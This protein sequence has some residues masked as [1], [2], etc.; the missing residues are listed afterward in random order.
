MKK[1]REY[2]LDTCTLIEF[3]GGNPSVVKHVMEAGPELCCMSVI[4]LHELYYGAYYAGEKKEEYYEREMKMIDK[5]LEKFSVLSLPEKAIGYAQIKNQLRKKGQLIDE[6]DM[7]IAGQA[8]DENLI[9]ITDNL[10]H[11][12]RIDG[13]KVENWMER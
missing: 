2:L 11:F 3:N 9:V 12:E 13:L 10:D 6:F 8:L 5:D 7:L 4:S 1:N